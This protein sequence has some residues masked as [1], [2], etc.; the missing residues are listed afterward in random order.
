M[1]SYLIVLYVLKCGYNSIFCRCVIHVVFNLLWIAR[2]QFIDN[3]FLSFVTSNRRS[4]TNYKASVAQALKPCGQVLPGHRIFSLLIDCFPYC[5][6]GFSSKKLI[7]GNRY[8][9]EICHIS[10]RNYIISRCFNMQ[11]APR[12]LCIFDLEKK[13]QSN[14]LE[15]ISTIRRCQIT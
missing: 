11:H 6:I 7:F 14:T 4:F 5:V 1:Y 9:V 3:D 13:N 10:H 12:I 8:L 2:L 15:E